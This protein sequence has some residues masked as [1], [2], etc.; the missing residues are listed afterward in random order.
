MFQRS[1]GWEPS[2]KQC[3]WHRDPTE[4]SA[5]TSEHFFR[6]GSG[7]CIDGSDFVST[8]WE[9]SGVCDS[10]GFRGG[11]GGGGSGVCGM[12]VEAAAVDAV[13]W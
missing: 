10:G 12:V 8:G 4:A 9:S 1:M 3:W 2:R 5:S 6:G 11:G 13:G 7:S